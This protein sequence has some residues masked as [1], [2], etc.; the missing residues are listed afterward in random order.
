MTRLARRGAILAV[1]VCLARFAAGCTTT[2]D[3][4]S[5][6]Y[7][8]HPEYRTEPAY[9]HPADPDEVDPNR[10]RAW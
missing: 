8:A 9:M 3:G 7:D 4:S 1:L 2:Y 6:F 10:G 5:S